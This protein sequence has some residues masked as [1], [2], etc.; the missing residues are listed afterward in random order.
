MATA[1]A[2][3]AVYRVTS[4]TEGGPDRIN[5]NFNQESG[6]GETQLYSNP[7][8]LNLSPEEAANYF[9]GQKYDVTFT[10][11]TT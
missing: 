8:S 5:V 2:H 4:V 7:I 1:T 6:E 9:P 10:P 3:T 11:Q